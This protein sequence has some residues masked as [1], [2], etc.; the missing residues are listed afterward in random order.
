MSELVKRILS[1]IVFVI[2]LVGATLWNVYAFSALFLLIC[3]LSL[4]EYNRLLLPE[5][6]ASY[7][8][9]SLICGVIIFLFAANLNSILPQLLNSENYDSL[10]PGATALLQFWEKLFSARSFLAVLS[11]LGWILLLWFLLHSHEQPFAAA[12]KTVLG[13]IYVS[14]PLGIFTGFYQD[15]QLGYRLPLSILLLVWSNDTFAYVWGRLLGKHK[16]APS[17]SPG[18]TW[19]G[20][21]GGLLSTAALSVWLSS[22]LLMSPWW[23]GMMLGITVSFAATAGDLVESR[24]K[25]SLGIKDSGNIM[26]GHGGALDRFDALLL[27]APA[28]YTLLAVFHNLYR[29][30]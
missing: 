20:F 17:I 16:M 30:F 1:G 9:L 15:I 8:R 4:S 2:L 14:V 11:V 19:E 6:P 7:R 26:P 24:L 25:R 23:L 13:W 29:L 3:I 12:G 22:E 5:L 18:K 28:T 27:A 10:S 21:A